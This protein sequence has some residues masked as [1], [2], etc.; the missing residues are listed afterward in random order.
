[1]VDRIEDQANLVFVACHIQELEQRISA[2][3]EQ[4]AT[5][6]LQSYETQNQQALLI[7]ML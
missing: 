5:M 6:V 4:M 7:S 1:M 2:L 3:R